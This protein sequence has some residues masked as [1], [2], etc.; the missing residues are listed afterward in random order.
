MRPM[1]HLLLLAVS[2]T[3]LALGAAASPAGATRF[4]STLSIPPSFGAS[5]QVLF[6][7]ASSGTSSADEVTLPGGTFRGTA[8]APVTANPPITN[9]VVKIQG[10][11]SAN[12]T[13][14]PLA[15]SR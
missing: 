5:A 8:S 6:E 11:G 1:R 7:G 15:P 12:F 14:N 9:L 3:A 10:N 2:G 13:G 4:R